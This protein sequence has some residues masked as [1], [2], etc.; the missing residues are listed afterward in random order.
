MSVLRSDSVLSRT[1]Q[2]QLP[3]PVPFL[4]L[5]ANLG[6][7]A[8]ACG[9]LAG[10]MV[11]HH[12]QSPCLG[13]VVPGSAMQNVLG[14]LM[15]IQHLALVQGPSQALR[16]HHWCSPVPYQQPSPPVQPHY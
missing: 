15:P 12:A 4:S 14:H 10:S 2:T 5:P 9:V 8:N 3:S 1:L 13:A 11:P 6:K 16:C 7:A